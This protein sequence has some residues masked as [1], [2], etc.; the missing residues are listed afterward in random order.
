MK[1]L[2]IYASSDLQNRIVTAIQ[3]AGADTFLT[4]D[5]ATAHRFN[6][7][8]DLPRTMT[9]EAVMFLVPGLSNEQANQL[10]EALGEECGDGDRRPCLRMT[11][12]DVDA[13]W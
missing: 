5:G 11:M 2:T 6:R 12:S 10:S 7:S 8:H 4:L 3:E 9:W 13:S 1:M